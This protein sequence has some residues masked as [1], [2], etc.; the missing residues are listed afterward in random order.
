MPRFPSPRRRLASP[1][2]LPPDE[3]AETTYRRTPAWP[4][5]RAARLPT[6]EDS[7]LYSAG[8]VVQSEEPMA[9]SEGLHEAT[10]DLAERIQRAVDSDAEREAV[11]QRW[12]GR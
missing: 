6:V 3:P 4:S 8:P 2:V 12:R 11:R 9:R 10:A 7:L 1:R 5:P